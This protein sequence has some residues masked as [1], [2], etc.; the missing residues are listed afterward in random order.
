M[1]CKLKFDRFRPVLFAVMGI[2]RWVQ[3][4]QKE[5][6]DKEFLGHKHK[7]LLSLFCIVCLFEYLW[8]RVL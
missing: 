1:F 5:S 4:K 3:K 8:D 2:Y 6:I 7:V